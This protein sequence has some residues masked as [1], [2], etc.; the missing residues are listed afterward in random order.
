MFENLMYE[1]NAYVG[2]CYGMRWQHYATMQLSM[3]WVA[4]LG[5]SILELVMT[6]WRQRYSTSLFYAYPR[7][8][9]RPLY[10]EPDLKTKIKHH[11][12]II[13]PTMLT[14]CVVASGLSE[15]YIPNHRLKVVTPSFYQNQLA[16]MFRQFNVRMSVPSIETLR[17]TYAR[18]SCLQEEIT[19]PKAG[20]FA[21]D[22]LRNF[23]YLCRTTN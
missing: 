3:A 12:T 2:K 17:H 18:R 14:E 22:L 7:H 16:A 8:R 5:L 1:M 10:F 13:A 20:D 21:T 11:H 23:I 9:G 15:A 6:Q 19:P 4:Y